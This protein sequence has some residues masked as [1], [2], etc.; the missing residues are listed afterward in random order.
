MPL[1]GEDRFMSTMSIL[2]DVPRHDK[3]NISEKPHRDLLGTERRPADV[4]MARVLKTRP[5]SMASD[6][7][8]GSIHCDE[9]TRA[10]PKKLHR[11]VLRRPLKH[12]VA[13]ER[14]P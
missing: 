6:P 10:K 13:R 8:S 11:S 12:E 2:R 5:V 9:S 3:P 14:A 1:K 7:S 4:E